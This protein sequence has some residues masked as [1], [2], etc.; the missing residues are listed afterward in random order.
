VLELDELT[1]LTAWAEG[2]SEAAAYAPEHIDLLLA[3][4]RPGATW[5]AELGLPE[6]SLGSPK[7]SQRS[8]GS[9]E[10]P[11]HALARHHSTPCSLQ[12]KKTT[13]AKQTSTK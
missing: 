9:L 3:A 8:P 11:A 1:V 2:A 12:P 6:P 7:Q 10:R 4:A 5:R 13:P